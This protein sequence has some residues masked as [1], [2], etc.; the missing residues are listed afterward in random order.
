[1][2]TTNWIFFITAS[3][4]VLAIS[5]YMYSRREPAG[6]GRRLLMLMR[7]SALVL[8]VL[9]LVDPRFGSGARRARDHTRVVLDASL[10]MMPR[11]KDSVAWRK[12]VKEAQREGR[13]GVIIAGDRGWTVPPESLL[14]MRPFLNSSKLLPS[15]ISAAEAGAQRVIVVTDGAIEDA[16]DVR[17]WLPTLGVE[18][19]VRR[20]ETSNVPNRAV[21]E[22]EAPP[23]AE[24]GKPLQLRVG[25][26]ARAMPP[27]ANA[28]VVVR[29]N[30][31]V[32]ARTQLSLPV[33]GRVASAT[34]NLN[35]DGPRAGGFVRYD[36][37]FETI[38]SIPDDDVRSAYVFI[39]EEPAGVALVSFLPDWEPKFLHPVLEKALGLPVRTFLR[40]PNGSY[41]RGGNAL[42]AGQRVG[43]APVRRALAQAHLVVLHGVTESAPA[44][45]RD[46]AGRARRLIMLPADALAEPY[47]IGVGVMG[48]WYVSAEVPASP[49]AAFMQNTNVSELPALESVFTAPGVPGAWTPLHAGR[50]RRGGR[51]PIMMAYETD[52]RRTVVALAMG[53]WRWAFGDGTAR[54]VYTRMWS[55]VAGWVVQD[56]AQVAGAAIRPVKRTLQRGRP[57]GWVSPGL[58]L[59]SL[60][61]QIT[62]AGGRIIQQTSV[63]PQHADTAQTPALAPGHYRYAV[64]GF[65]F[66][67]EVAEA[68]GPFTVETYSAEFMRPSANLNEVRSGPSALLDM[69][70]SSA[71]PLHTSPWPYTVLVLLL[72]AEWI[73]R[74]R[75]GLR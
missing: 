35:V 57:I 63:V 38:D 31:N 14:T 55:S 68:A 24:A 11:A 15:L 75:W 29:Q 48:D 64:R 9:L 10:S 18:L 16:A 7:A 19:D 61:V 4:V 53:Y 59:D 32:I 56:E 74:R 40:M 37:G 44:W 62:G 43:E 54:D 66:G 2:T 52:N 3:A 30:G 41:F 26:S 36:V 20:I 23:W 51:S 67:A 17:R 72:C 69:S 34:I 1:M 70:R 42:E 25:V 50:T 33:D 13:G 47:E 46:V 5:W 28:P 8:I 60:Q 65:A 45:W 6:R 49:V 27:D 73:L 58:A 12:A 71:R 22:L 39:S 21:T